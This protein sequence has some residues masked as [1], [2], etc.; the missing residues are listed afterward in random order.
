M[1]QWPGKAG[2]ERTTFGGLLR[3]E[4]MSHIQSSGNKTTE[5]RL[6]DLLRAAHVT[7]WRR[8]QPLLGHPDFIW[9]RVR[10]AVFVDGCFWHGHDCSRNLTPKKNAKAWQQ[11][12]NRNKARDRSVNRNLRNRGWSVLRIWECR[13]ARSPDACVNRIYRKIIEKKIF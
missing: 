4:L 1:S 6:I 13:L 3:S 12:I 8:H 9:P 11:K 10:V 7:G 2:E 5:K